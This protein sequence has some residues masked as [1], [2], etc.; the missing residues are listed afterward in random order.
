MGYLIL[1]FIL[2]V[3]V[4]WFWQSQFSRPPAFQQLVHKELAVHGHLGSVSALKKRIEDM[5]KMLD[6]LQGASPSL[7]PADTEPDRAVRP[8]IASLQG[9][10]YRSAETE[11]RRDRS[12]KKRGEVIHLWKEG[13]PVAEIASHTRLGTGEIELIIALENSAAG[14]AGTAGVSAA[15]VPR[16]LPETMEKIPGEVL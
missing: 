6:G 4:S 8:V 13:R 3:S 1:G 2:G 12:R 15:Q 16:P 11:G 9:G 7:P 14:D 5:E 10:S